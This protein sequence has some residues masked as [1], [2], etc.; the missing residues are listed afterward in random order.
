MDFGLSP[1][2]T[3]NQLDLHGRLLTFASITSEGMGITRFIQ[4]KLRPV[5]TER[6][7]GLGVIVIGDPAGSQRAQTDERSCFDILKAEGFRVLP[8]ST[9]SVVARIAAVEKLLSR[10]VEGRA[11]HLIDPSATE[12]I[13]AMRGGYRYKIKKSGEMEASP[14]KN[15]HS[16][17]ADAHQYACLYAEGGNMF[18][19]TMRTEK[20]EIKRVSAG[21]WT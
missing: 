2:A 4:E 13:R 12:L 10:Q 20:R 6:F 16:H 8:A 5:L 7:A 1:A 11:G 18:G 14:E 15:S 19:G 3:I 21:G 17:I 9:N